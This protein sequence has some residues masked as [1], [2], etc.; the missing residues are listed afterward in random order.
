MYFDYYN[1]NTI[2]YEGNSY[3]FID[4]HKKKSDLFQNRIRNIYDQLK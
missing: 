2:K 4:T 3:S 1:T